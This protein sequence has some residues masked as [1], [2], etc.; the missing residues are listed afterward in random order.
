[1]KQMPIRVR[2]ALWYMVIFSVAQLAFGVA[3]WLLLRDSLYNT[4]SADLIE[5]VAAVQFFL[6]LQRPTSTP[7]HLRD[8]FIEDYDPKEGTWLQVIDQDGNWLYRSAKA[9]AAMP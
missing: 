2:L 8:E 5:H 6:S 1:M 3:A 9:A 4:V 7:A